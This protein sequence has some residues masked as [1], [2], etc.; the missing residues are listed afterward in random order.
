MVSSGLIISW[1][2]RVTCASEVPVWSEEEE[3]E[4]KLSCFAKS[5]MD[6]WKYFIMAAYPLFEEEEKGG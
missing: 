4:E 6:R 3:E 5:V 2:S 1:L